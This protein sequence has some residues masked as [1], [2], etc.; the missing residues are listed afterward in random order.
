MTE[1]KQDGRDRRLS[2]IKIYLKDFSFESP[3]SPGVF[4]GKDWNPDTNLNLRSA[5]K[6]LDDNLHEVVLT[7]TVETKEREGE[8]KT[9]FLLEIQQAGIF[10]LNGYSR[11]E[12][13]ALIGSF[14][15]NVLFP[16]ARETVASIVQ[17]GGFPEFV[18]QPINFDALYLQSLQQQKQEGEA[19][20]ETH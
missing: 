14:A 4:Q 17:K 20:P 10:E 18:M 6:Q 2:I 8:N 11:E 13:G 1:Q 15:P 3:R 7:I 9:L 5:H 16:Y 19:A 12:M